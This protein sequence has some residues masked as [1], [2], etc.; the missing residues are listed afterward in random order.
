MARY[1]VPPDI[2]EAIDKAD[3]LTRGPAHITRRTANRKMIAHLSERINTIYD[4]GIPFFTR[5][6]IKDVVR[7]FNHLTTDLKLGDKTTLTFTVQGL[8]GI[9]VDIPV[10]LGTVE[11]YRDE[12]DLDIVS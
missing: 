6:A 12:P 11:P 1:P 5:D 10:E 9:Y 7:Q 8:D 4:S 2:M 3:S